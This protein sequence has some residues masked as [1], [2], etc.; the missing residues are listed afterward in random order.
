MTYSQFIE[1]FKEIGRER[2]HN[3]SSLAELLERN[4]SSLYKTLS[5]GKIQVSHLFKLAD[6]FD[7]DVMEFFITGPLDDRD[8]E[9][10][11][12]ELESAQNEIKSLRETIEAK[13]ELIKLLK[14]Q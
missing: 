3:M 5:Q 12:L 13:D 10:H 9:I 7:I 1:R 14:S 11:R 4:E 6:A 8:R 2:G